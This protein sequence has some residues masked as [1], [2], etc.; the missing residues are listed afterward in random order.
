MATLTFFGWWR[1]PGSSAISSSTITAG[2][3]S[4]SVQLTARDLDN[5][6]DSATR[7]VNY[8]LFGPGDVKG[9]GPGAIVHTYPSPGAR[10]VEIEKAVY[11]ELGAPDLAWRYTL[12]RPQG[13]VLR[14]WMVLLVGTTTEIDVRGQTVRLQPTV[15]DAHPLNL[16]A[17]GAH[18]EQDQNLRTVGRLISPRPLEPDRDHVAVIVPAFTVTGAS[19]WPTPASEPVEL[20]LFYN[21]TFHTRAGGDFAALARRLKLRTPGADFG[22]VSV[23]YTPL[24]GAAA[25]RVGGALVATKPTPPELPHD[26]R[27]DL[28]E[29]TA[30]LGDPAHPVLGLP[31]YDA[32]WP[33]PPAP[34]P[35]TGWRDQLRVDYRVRAIAGLGAEAGIANQELLA[36]EAGRVAGAYEE[37]AARLRQMTLGLLASRSLWK[38]RVSTNPTRRLGMFGPALRDVLSDAGPVAEVMEHPDR[39]F[40]R[41][42]FS[43]AAQRAVRV[44]GEPDASVT[45]AAPAA[46]GMGAVLRQSAAAPPPR[47]A[48]PSTMCSSEQR[49]I[50][51][52]CG[53]RRC[54]WPTRST[55]ATSI[56]TRSRCSIASW[57]RSSTS[58]AEDRQC[59]SCHCWRWSMLARGRRAND[60]ACW[61]PHWTR[62]RIPMTSPRS[63]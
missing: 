57:E 6:S 17:R 48:L 38:R 58:S 22:T 49:L 29:L 24:P 9:L 31:D 46:S 21:W 50:P 32:P 52:A 61:P 59:R 23:D 28:A 60:C 34:P 12:A 27:A 3:L 18:V 15:L 37:A 26:V 7:T 10:N 30:P 11:A 55:A 53:R 36:R 56:W 54:D 43:S 20:P 4:A 41:T 39:A 1:P 40:E 63:A 16:S 8:D 25:M 13:R 2:R 47:T 44:R 35:P 5:T 62:S 19:S 14:P 45:P 33:P 42:L 51:D